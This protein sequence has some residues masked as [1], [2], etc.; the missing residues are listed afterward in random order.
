MPQAAGPGCGPPVE[1]VRLQDDTDSLGEGEAAGEQS[2]YEFD[3]DFD[4]WVW[5]GQDVRDEFAESLPDDDMAASAGANCITSWTKPHIDGVIV[6]FRARDGGVWDD[7]DIVHVSAEAADA[8]GDGKLGLNDVKT[9]A[10]GE[11][12]SLTFNGRGIDLNEDAKVDLLASV[13]P[14]GIVFRMIGVDNNTEMDGADGLGGGISLVNGD[15][16]LEA[17]FARDGKITP[18]E[19]MQLFSEEMPVTLAYE[20]VWFSG[21][22]AFL[23]GRV[24]DLASWGADRTIS[25]ASYDFAATG[26]T[27][28]ADTAGFVQVPYVQ[29]PNEKPAT[30]DE[31]PI[32]EEVLGSTGDFEA[33]GIVVRMVGVDQ[34]TSNTEAA[35]VVIRMLGVHNDT[36]SADADGFVQVPFVQ[37]PGEKPATA[38]WPIVIDILGSTRDFETADGGQA[39]LASPASTAGQSGGAV[40]PGGVVSGHISKG[41]LGGIMGGPMGMI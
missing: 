1:V 35:G 41:V 6:E 38:E 8:D 14:D 29:E 37:E 30:A 10:A 27:S 5:F 21:A 39:P 12:T 9:N 13:E 3:L 11:P 26:P 19:R 22:Q 28:T 17:R 34:D 36:S 31:R 32:I 33:D 7:T 40:D 25:A 16:A 15:F 20:P 24:V 23:R 18:W 2:G 4:E